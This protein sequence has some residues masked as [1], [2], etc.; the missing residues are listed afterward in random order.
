MRALALC[1]TVVAVATLGTACTSDRPPVSAAPSSASV[2]TLVPEFGG[3]PVLPP[4]DLR[5]DGPGSLVEVTPL[6][7]QNYFELVDATSV[8]VVYR[9]TRGLDG[10]PTRVSGVV[11][12]PPGNP[13]PGGWPI[14]SFGHAGLGVA[15]PCAPSLGDDVAG[16]APIMSVMLSRGYVVTLSDYAGLGLAGDP[17]SVIDTTT[18]GNN[19]VDA[20]RAARRVIPT[21]STKWA[22][23]G[24]GE[25]GQASWAANERAVDYGAGLQMVGAAALSPLVDMTGLVDAAVAGTMTPVQYR[26]FAQVLS[27]VASTSPNFDLDRYRSAF[28]RDQWTDLINCGG[29]PEAMNSRLARLQPADLRPPDK[30]A[31][32][33]LRAILAPYV[34]P[35]AS[36]LAAPLLVVYATEDPLVS[37]AWVVGAL[38]RACDKGDA[39][40][41]RPQIG[42][43]STE[44]DQALQ[45][46]LDWLQARFDGQQLSEVCRGAA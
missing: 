3:A 19:V 46:S 17:H 9:S 15:N 45:S 32:A 24:F 18:L 4:P 41:Y 25:G 26:L 44:T 14:I 21:A 30:A 27:S 6:T 37:R 35:G 23:W 33:E 7:N 40:E 12:V 38:E 8:R 34:L 2:P 39:V 11:A 43:S 42:A 16:Y 13:P 29:A 28:V 1:V 5:D 22:A 20:V 36:G 31:A 10:E